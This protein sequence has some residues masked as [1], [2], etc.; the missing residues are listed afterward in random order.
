MDLNVMFVSE[1]TETT[2]DIFFLII[3]PLSIHDLFLKRCFGFSDRRYC[4]CI[5]R[6][7]IEPRWAVYIGYRTWGTRILLQIDLDYN[8]NLPNIDLP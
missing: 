5:L 7:Y 2:T 3:L 6:Y 4:Y 8:S 1:A